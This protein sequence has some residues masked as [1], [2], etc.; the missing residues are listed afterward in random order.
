MVLTPKRHNSHRRLLAAHGHHAIAVE[1]GAIDDEPHAKCAGGSFQHEP[2]TI[3]ANAPDLGLGAHAATGVL[4]EFGQSPAHLTEVDDSR[5]GHMDRI[6]PRR[7]R[8]QL[9]QARPGD[10]LAPH[11]IGQSPLI[12][13][14]EGRDLTFVDGHDDLAAPV[15]GNL[16]FP[17]EVLQGPPAGAAVRGLQRARCIVDARMQDARIAATLVLADFSFLLE[18]LDGLSA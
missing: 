13:P 16:L 18:H 11:A 12:D 14:F 15:K 2:V 10:P 9:M 3:A 17:A 4:Y 7:V 5:L 1:S 8:L 6:D